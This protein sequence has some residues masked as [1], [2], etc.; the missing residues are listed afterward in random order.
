VPKK[1]KRVTKTIEKYDENG[2]FIGR[3]IITEEYEDV[4]KIVYEQIP[5]V[6]PHQPTYQPW[7]NDP[8]VWCDSGNSSLC[9]N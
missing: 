2:K 3:E 5:Y 1:V 6:T 9:I 4:E 8:P 7:Y